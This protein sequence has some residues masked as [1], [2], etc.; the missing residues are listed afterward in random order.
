MAVGGTRLHFPAG[1]GCPW[2]FPVPASARLVTF[3]SRTRAIDAIEAASRWLCHFPGPP[4]VIARVF[5]SPPSPR[6]SDHPTAAQSPADFI[7]RFAVHAARRP[8]RHVRS[9]WQ[10][11]HGH[12]DAAQLPKIPPAIATR[13]AEYAATAGRQ[14]ICRPRPRPIGQVAQAGRA[15]VRSRP[16][17]GIL[18]RPFPVARRHIP[19]S[20]PPVRV[21]RRP[22]G[23][24]GL[25]IPARAN[26]RPMPRRTESGAGKPESTITHPGAARAPRCARA[27]GHG[28]FAP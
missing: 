14:P 8:R 2:P 22:A 11:Q 23:H 12:V 9:G 1:S 5:L 4:R 18:V 24:A 3:T 21:G 6:P 15:R 13:L 7:C 20:R 28:F 17:G 10:H 16:S 25:P 27:R 26:P 19:H